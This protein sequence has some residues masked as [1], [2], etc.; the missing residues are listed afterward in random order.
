MKKFWLF[1][2]GIGIMGVQALKAQEVIELYPG[3]NTRV[4]N[5]SRFL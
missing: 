1:G 3:K 5:C 2:L 4:K